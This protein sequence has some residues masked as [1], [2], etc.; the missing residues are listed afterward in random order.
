MTSTSALPFARV[1]SADQ[2]IHLRRSGP[3]PIARTNLMKI[4]LDPTWIGTF[5]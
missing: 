4:A 5:A 3:K 2:I 1:T